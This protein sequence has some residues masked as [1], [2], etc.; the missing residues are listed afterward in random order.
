MIYI[1]KI[2]S[3]LRYLRFIKSFQNMN[4]LL[5][6]TDFSSIADNALNYAIEMSKKYQ[7]DILLYNVVQL[8]TPDFSHLANVE[9]FSHIVVE[10]QKKMEE[11]TSILQAQHPDVA[12]AC[13]V[14]TGLLI[15]SINDKSDAINPVAIL[16][17]ITGSGTGID[18]LIGSNAILAMKHIKHPVIIVPKDAT[19]N[20]I[21]QICFACDLK[22]VLTSTPL[23][24]IKVFTK[25]FDVL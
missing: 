7:F 23:I 22:N 16:M 20:P 12:F 6:P 10:I 14:D 18:K 17:G 3:Q 8:S 13:A 21:H 4:T 19:F 11:K 9:D 2:I 15:E 1:T 25:L 24:S 5:V